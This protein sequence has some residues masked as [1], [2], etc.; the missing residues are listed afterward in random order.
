MAFNLCHCFKKK[1]KSL[2]PSK[3]K[4]YGAYVEKMLSW[5]AYFENFFCINEHRT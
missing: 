3:P 5:G 2:F 1:K 4:F